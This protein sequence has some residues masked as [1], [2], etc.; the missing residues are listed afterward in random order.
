MKR[1]LPLTIAQLL[2]C[3]SINYAQ[4]NIE[5]FRIAADSLGFSVR[6]DL[7]FTIMVGNS[8]FQYMGTNTRFH[9]N[10][11]SHYTFLVIKLAV[12]V[13]FN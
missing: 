13:Q 5:T 12:A 11:G 2:V 7:D 6:S 8:E 4:V 9:F 3:F 1:L 10:W